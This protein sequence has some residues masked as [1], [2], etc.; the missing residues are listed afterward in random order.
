MSRS[1]TFEWFGRF[2]NGRTSTANDDRSGRP[3]TATI[4]S[5]VEQVRAVSTRIVV[6][7]YAISV[8]VG[9][10]YGSCQRILTEQLNTHRIAAKF[11]PRVLTQ[12]QKDSRVAICQELKETV[13]NDP[14][15]LLNIIT[16]DESIVCAYHLE[17]K[18][19]SSQWKR[20]GSKRPKKAHKQKSKLKT[21]MSCFFDQEGIV[22]WEFVPPGMTVN[23][24]F[25]CAVLRR[26]H[27]NVRRKRPQKWQNQNL[28]IHHDNAPAHRSFKVLQF[29]AKNYMTVI[30]HPPYSPDLA[31][32]DFF[33]F[34]KLKLRMKGRRFDTIQE[35]QEESQW[36]LDTFPKRD[37]QGCFQA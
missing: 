17:T 1:R 19:Q 30:P 21:M 10:G 26:L 5:K 27:E 35:I 33:L 11:V 32:C 16:G 9:I 31:P 37:L 22:H 23:A 8:Q 14:T 12:D 3:S 25:Y 2:K 15:L 24:H 6:V 20:P 34:P 7:P 18:L 28:I 29:L 13:I 36:L 4:P